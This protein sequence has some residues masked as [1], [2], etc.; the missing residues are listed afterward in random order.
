MG[1]AK[2]SAFWVDYQNRVACN[3]I[4]AIDNITS[5]DPRVAGTNSIGSFSI[6]ADGMQTLV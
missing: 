2:R 3:G 5:K 1:G 6:D 4:A